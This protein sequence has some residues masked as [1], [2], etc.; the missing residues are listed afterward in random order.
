MLVLYFLLFVGFRV[1][2]KVLEHFSA[3]SFGFGSAVVFFRV[4]VKLPL[5]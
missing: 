2:F 5:F 4:F 3:Y 1:L